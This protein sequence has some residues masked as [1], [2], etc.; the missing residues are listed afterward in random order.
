M[1]ESAAI[2][3]P[4]LRR[5]FDKFWE[6]LKAGTDECIAHA[7]DNQAASQ[8]RAPSEVLGDVLTEIRGLSRDSQE[9]KRVVTA[10]ISSLMLAF[11]RPSSIRLPQPDASTRVYGLLGGLV[12]GGGQLPPSTQDAGVLFGTTHLQ[13]GPAADLSIDDIAQ[14]YG[15]DSTTHQPI[16]KKSVAARRAKANKTKW[17]K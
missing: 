10:L 5:T 6:E 2:P 13:P 3:E 9:Q 8:A 16:V 4:L 15:W 1:R 11:P 17:P 12:G 7:S 14:N